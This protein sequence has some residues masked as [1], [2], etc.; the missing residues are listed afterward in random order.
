MK[1]PAHACTCSGAFNCFCAALTL[2]LPHPQSKKKQPLG[3]WLQS[4]AHPCEI[5]NSELLQVLESLGSVRSEAV[6]PAAEP[7]AHK[8]KRPPRKQVKDAAPVQ[9]FRFLREHQRENT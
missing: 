5:S 8:L 3:Q 1:Q 9:L 6:E 7:Q 4:H 2:P